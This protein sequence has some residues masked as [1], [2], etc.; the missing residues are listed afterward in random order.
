[1]LNI[2]GDLFSAFDKNIQVDAAFLDCSKAFDVVPHD[3]LML[4]L[5]H[6]GVDGKIHKWIG[7]FLQHRKQCVVIEGC[8][9]SSMDVI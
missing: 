8:S 6:Y 4:K 3:R 1:M 2:T 7:Q 5:E 9:S